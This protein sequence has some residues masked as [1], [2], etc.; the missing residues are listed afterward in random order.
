MA[1][2]RTRAHVDEQAVP[3]KMLGRAE[4]E[5]NMLRTPGNIASSLDEIGGLRLQT[6]IA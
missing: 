2:T 1:S 6:N 4:I 5:E 3:V